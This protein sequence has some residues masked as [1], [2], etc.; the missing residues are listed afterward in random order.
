[1]PVAI[2][3]FILRESLLELWCRDCDW[4]C[5]GVLYDVTP[6]L[7]LVPV[8]IHRFILGKVFW[9]SDVIVAISIILGFVLCYSFT[10]VGNVAF[11]IVSYGVVWTFTGLSNR[12]CD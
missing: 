7:S 10:L 11:I 12:N 4:Y 2:H 3:R 1:M 8:A 9:S 6:S 5:L